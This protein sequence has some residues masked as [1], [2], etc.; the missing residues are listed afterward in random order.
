MKIVL[1]VT[2]LLTI[3]CATT[4]TKRGSDGYDKGP[5]WT[6]GEVPS[7]YV[8][9]YLTAVGH[10]S[11]RE[12]AESNAKQALAEIFASKIKSISQSDKS[13]TFSDGVESDSTNYANNVTVETDIELK[14]V[15]IAKT[16]YD[17]S[18]IAHYAL[19]VLNKNVAKKM[20]RDELSDLRQ[21]VAAL[22]NSFK[23][24]PKIGPANKI[25]KK[26]AEFEQINIQYAVVNDG[27]RMMSPIS[28]ATWQEI[29]SAAQAVSMKNFIYLTF[30][31][32]YDDFKDLVS[33]CLS[34]QNI[35]VVTSEDRKK[36]SAF[37]VKVK[38]TEQKIP[39]SVKGWVNYEYTA[40]AAIRN[41][42]KGKLLE[43]VTVTKDAKHKRKKSCYLRVK[44]SLSQEVCNQVF[45]YVAR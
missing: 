9:S 17:K 43:K 13:Y 34:E 5:A 26:T 32:A 11:S 45:K 8:S 15:K 38:L 19:A 4:S 29:E 7:K 36:D 37:S 33:S 12:G 25:K 31:G 14:N 22:A 20:Y 3:S 39:I 23:K 21:E 35:K 1:I 40:V 27:K 41:L 44:N 28:A 30:S 42:K 2:L 6:T 16:Y 18:M 10:A 24:D